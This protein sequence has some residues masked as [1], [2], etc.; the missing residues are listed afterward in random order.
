M[1]SYCCV[2]GCKSYKKNETG[3]NKSFHRFPVSHHTRRAW[4]AKI[5]RDIGPH[6]QITEN[7]RVCG[8]HFTEDCFIKTG[9]GKM[10]LQAGTVPTVFAWSSTNTGR[11]TSNRSRLCEAVEV[12]TPQDA[13]ASTSR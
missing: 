12:G 5:K 4:I 7:T 2:P 13:D 6:F 9:T 10:K 11:R 1:S 3:R 8:D